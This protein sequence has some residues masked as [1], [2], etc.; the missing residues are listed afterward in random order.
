MNNKNHT[1]DHIK[2]MLMEADEAPRKILDLCSQQVIHPK[3]ITLKEISVRLGTMAQLLR[4]SLNN[5]MWDFTEKEL[6]SKI[7][8]KDY[9]NL[10]WSHDFPIESSEKTSGT[11]NQKFL[12][13]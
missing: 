10:H 9:E 7:N 13:T 2:I 1:P 5:M 3:D 6:K 11:Q 12:S 4:S 8:Q